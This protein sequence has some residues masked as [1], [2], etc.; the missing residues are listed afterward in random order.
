[1]KARRRILPLFLPRSIAVVATVLSVSLAASPAWG[2][3][4][5][6]LR[7]P[8]HTK[9]VP[10]TEPG[11]TSDTVECPADRPVATSG[12][13]EITGN[14]TGLDLEVGTTLPEGAADKGWTVVANNSSPAAAS[15]KPYA[16]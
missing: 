2:L 8:S 10:N 11:V 12:G 9:D 14:Q 6:P 15:M 13:A 4:A 1:M 3:R 5:G 7:Y 16:I